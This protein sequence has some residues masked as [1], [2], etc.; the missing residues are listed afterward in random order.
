MNIGIAGNPGVG[1][2][3]YMKG[4]VLRDIEK[5]KKWFNTCQ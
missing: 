2:T 4:M 1:K 3:T 5:H